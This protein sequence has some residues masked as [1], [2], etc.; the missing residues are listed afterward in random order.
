MSEDEI[1]A[2]WATAVDQLRLGVK[3][4]RIV[5]VP[6]AGRSAARVR[7]ADAVH[8]YK[9]ERCRTCGGPVEQAEIDNRNSFACPTCQPRP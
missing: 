8:V 2:I 5:T 7:R 1:R 6:L 4:N 9:Q 3:R